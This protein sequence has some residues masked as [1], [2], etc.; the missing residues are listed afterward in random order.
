MAEAGERTLRPMLETASGRTAKSER[1]GY[2]QSAL[3]L[4][5][6]GAVPWH[7]RRRPACC[8]AVSSIALHKLARPAA[9]RFP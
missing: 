1:P 9:G 5:Q 4:L 2:D 3:V 8:R 6:L 7:V